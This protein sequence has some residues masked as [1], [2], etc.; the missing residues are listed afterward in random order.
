MAGHRQIPLKIKP[1]LLTSYFK[2]ANDIERNLSTKVEGKPLCS[3]V[4]MV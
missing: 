4:F 2:T 3:S 1:R